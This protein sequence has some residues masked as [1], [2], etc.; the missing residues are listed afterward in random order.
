MRN[1]VILSGALAALVLATTAYA[2]QTHT[3]LT[4][5][6]GDASEALASQVV[7]T[8]TNL[9]PEAPERARTRADMMPVRVRIPAIGLNDPIQNMDLLS[10]GALDVPPGST[11]NVGW[12]QGGTLPGKK[13]SAVLDAHV[14]AAFKDLKYVKAGDDI[15]I[16]EADGTT[17]HF[18][19]AESVVY[20]L[21]STPAEL[22]YNQNDRPRLNLIT[23]AGQLVADHSTY[24]HRLI[25][26]AVL[27]K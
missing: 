21:A 20:P 8:T 17:I 9:F 23:C 26:Y 27:A 12:W 4:P 10:N 14:F 13:G 3:P 1:S 7:S 16:D 25:V 15:Y 18:V 19:A 24:D 2:S 5:N 11:K 6:T 22:L